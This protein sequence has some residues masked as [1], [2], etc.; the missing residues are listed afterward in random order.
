M[1]I[2]SNDKGTLQKTSSGIIYH[3]TRSHLEVGKSYTLS[4]DE[5]TYTIQ[6]DYEIRTKSQEQNLN[7]GR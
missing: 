6:Q 3:S 2:Q 5:K 4:H 7:K 1:I